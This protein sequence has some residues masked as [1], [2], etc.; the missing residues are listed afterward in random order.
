MDKTINGL[1]ILS[2]TVGIVQTNC[3][4]VGMVNK[5]GCIIIDP[6]GEEDAILRI[7]DQSGYRVEGILLT[8]GHFD[9]ILGIEGIRKRYGA[10]VY[11]HEEEKELLGKKEWNSSTITGSPYECVPDILL[12]DGEVVT[13]AGIGIT[14]LHTPGHTKGGVCYHLKNYGVLFSGDTLFYESIGRTDLPT[15][16]GNQ[17]LH[18]I[19]NKL[20]V[21]DEDTKVYPGHGEATLI[22]HEKTGN[23]YLSFI[24][25]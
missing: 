12:Q 2:E 16:D 6:G 21:L 3:Y 17:I 25:S 15:A 4:I 23:P 18:S 24:D 1:R 9:H 5:D 13:L 10:K 22:G 14:V 7:V 20:L 8:H 19:K 11:A